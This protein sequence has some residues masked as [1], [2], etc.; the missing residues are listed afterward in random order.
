M[1]RQSLEWIRNKINDALFNC[2]SAESDEFESIAAD[3]DQLC[4]VYDS[5][6]RIIECEE[7]CK[8][9]DLVDDMKRLFGTTEA[10][11]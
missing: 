8:A 1:N 2:S 11:R 6:K 3:F 4:S 10:T 7:C 9:L 5:A